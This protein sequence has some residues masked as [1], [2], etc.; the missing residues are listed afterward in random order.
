MKKPKKK[1][2]SAKVGNPTAAPS[3][4]YEKF[5]LPNGLQVIFHV[6]RKLPVVHVN[7]WFHVGSK[8]ERPGRTGFAHLF[9]H[10]MFQGSVNAT[11]EYFAHVERA[12]ANLRE[13]GVNGTTSEDRTNYFV[14]VPSANLAYVLWLESDRMATLADSLTQIELDNQR[15]VV[16]NERRQG[17]DNQPYGRAFKLITENLFPHGH[18]YSWP[19]IG[20]HEDLVAASMEDVK[21]FF[22]TFYTPNNLSLCIAGDFDPNEAKQ[23]IEK[24]YGSMPPG[25]A[26]D[27]PK[28]FVPALMG[29]KMVEVRDRV[30]QERIY[31]A[32]PSPQY[33]AK[34]EPELVLA[35]SI[36]TDGLSSRLNKKLVYE[37]QICSNVSS[38]N[39]ASE[40]AGAFVVIATARPGANLLRIEE[41]IAREIAAFAAKGPTRRELVRAKTKWEYD[42]I[43]GLERIGGFGGKADRLNAYN[44]YLGDPGKFGEDLT[45]YRNVTPGGVRTA[46]ERWIN[47]RNKLIVRFYPEQSGRAVSSTLDRTVIPALGVDREF[48]VPSVH[49]RQLEN[50]LNVLVVDRHELPKVSVVLATRAG[51]I[52]D[53]PDKM[54]VAQLAIRT[55]D[56]GTTS[57]DSIEIEEA[58][59]DLGTALH[60]LAARELSYL[61]FDVLTTN[62]AQALSILSDVVLRPTF[63][64]SE[65][66]R[67]RDLHMDSLK[68]ESNNPNAIAA[69][70]RPMLVFGRSHVYGRPARGVAATVGSVTRKDLIRFH[71]TYWKPND[72]ALVFTGDITVDEAMRMAKK[73]FG[74][75]IKGRVPAVEIPQP[76]PVGRGAIYL[77][78]RQDAAQTVISQ[79]LSGPG[80][81]TED[82]YLLKLAD[83]VWGGGFMTRLNLNLRE[84]KGYT[85]GVFSNLALFSRSGMWFAS[86]SVETTKTVEA[87]VEFVK[88]L[89]NLSG[90]MPISTQELAEA[91]ANRLRGFAQQFESLGR[92][93]GQVTELWSHGLPMS[94]LQREA[95]ELTKA[96]VDLVNV[97]ARRYANPANAMLLLV[98]DLSKI[99]KPIRELNLA[100]VVILD[101]EGNIVHE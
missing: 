75:W 20:S 4:Q 81:T 33:F 38:F 26:L 73:H 77:V 55:I 57:M 67:E 5:V 44:T 71:K 90:E 31:L 7:E 24:Y 12:G 78:D 21:Q 95:T 94:D 47:T 59:G 19:V 65:F 29:E 34:D 88:E 28:S 100:R 14:T 79:I 36:L 82:Y 9:E 41:I 92:V 83:A 35:S 42:F 46:V 89:K 64:G 25:P 76:E 6:D 30:P 15:E 63:P 56:R 39:D 53:P 68:Q 93:A 48:I 27:R 17:L 3:I 91:K 50:G 80:R 32:W 52:S 43:S 61:S 60:G 69:R 87:V 99:E 49:S 62:L 45:R 84:D 11:G 10:L 97:S 85:Y 86:G 16:R 70:V 96:T 51:S 2:N 54:G 72:S 23:L 40:I 37:L 1:T 58:F 98:G 13:G 18:P 22:K 8:N 74:S 66:E 101:V